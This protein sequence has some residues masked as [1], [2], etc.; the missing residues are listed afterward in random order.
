MT[1]NKNSK[2][3][4]FSQRYDPAT[5]I[6]KMVSTST[7]E[8][9]PSISHSA[10]QYFSCYFGTITCFQ[11]TINC[12]ITITIRIYLILHLHLPDTINCTNKTL[13]S[14]ESLQADGW[15]HNNKKPLLNLP[16]DLH[17]CL[18]LP[19]ILTLETLTA[20]LLVIPVF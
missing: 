8:Q 9:L 7:S 19:I 6:P 1:A 14:S 4:R 12:N 5:T 18:Q 3:L 13:C 10:V 20:V 16:S 2:K 11:A 15:G 17:N